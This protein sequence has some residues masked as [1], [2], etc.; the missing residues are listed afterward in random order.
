MIYTQT[1][2]NGEEIENLENAVVFKSK[3]NNRE[4]LPPYH[5]T[6]ESEWKGGH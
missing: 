4:S 3:Q 2:S 1:T 6:S 5:R